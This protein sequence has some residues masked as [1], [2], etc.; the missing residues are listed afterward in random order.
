MNHPLDRLL[1]VLTQELEL[2]RRLCALLDEERASLVGL[3]GESLLAL[4][5]EKDGLT[6][7]LKALEES[8]RLAMESLA[9]TLA[10]PNGAQCTLGEL[11]RQVG[12][13]HAT[14][15]RRLRGQLREVVEQGQSRNDDNRFLINRS[16]DMVRDAM[17]VL[18]QAADPKMYRGRKMAQAYQVT[19]QVVA[20]EA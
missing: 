20:R 18:S 14:A 17:R 8:R 10:L 16:L 4:A 7:Q 9:E 11:A 12:E 19:A 6:L 2:H 5:R 15:L 1:A 3:R 13:P